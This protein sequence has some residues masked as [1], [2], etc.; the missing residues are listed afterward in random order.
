MTPNSTR[1]CH[2]EDATY[3]MEGPHWSVVGSDDL[4][5]FFRAAEELAATGSVLCVA[6]GAWTAD[7]LEL[8]QRIS[9]DRERSPHPRLRISQGLPCSTWQTELTR[10][11]G[12]CG[13]PCGTGDRLSLCGFSGSEMLLEWFDAVGDPISVAASTPEPA[14]RQFSEQVGGQYRWMDEGV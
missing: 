2:D 4:P 5:R 14:V 9:V 13:V 3:L 6:D 11:G 10:H 8:L 12:D 7:V 1:E